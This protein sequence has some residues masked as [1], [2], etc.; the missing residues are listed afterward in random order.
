[1]SSVDK[2]PDWSVFKERELLSLEHELL[3]PAA[4]VAAVLRQRHAALDEARQA[5]A[6]IAQAGFVALAEQAVLAVQLELLLE[7]SLP[8]FSGVDSPVQGKRGSLSHI[9]KSLCIVKD[10]MFD[11]LKKAGIEIEVPLGKRYEEVADSVEVEQWQPRQDCREEVV[12]AVREPIVRMR[13]SDH[14]GGLVRVGRVNI[15]VPLEEVSTD[16]EG[17]VPSPPD[18]ERN[19]E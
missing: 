9:Y 15:G 14:P 16:E 4:E 11:A 12:I 1:M 10:Q 8:S 17:D 7:R 5:K 6:E 13:R 3:S 18:R 19:A 2:I